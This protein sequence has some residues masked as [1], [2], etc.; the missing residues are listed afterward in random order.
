MS[1]RNIVLAPAADGAEVRV[2][3]DGVVR[4]LRL[5]H[6]GRDEASSYF[7]P[8]D[9]GRAIAEYDRQEAERGSSDLAAD[10]HEKV[11]RITK[12]RDAWKA[13]ARAQAEA[14]RTLD[15][16]PVWDAKKTLHALNIDP[17]EP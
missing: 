1:A 5:A 7:D 13:L 15:R 12:E 8:A 14:E 11:E 6:I 3:I 2:C 4:L 9:R 10:V 17:E 16:R